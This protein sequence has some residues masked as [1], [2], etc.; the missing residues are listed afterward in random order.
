MTKKLESIRMLSI[1]IHAMIGIELIVMPST[2]VKCAKNNAW[3]CPILVGITILINVYQSFWVMEKFPGLN[4]AEINEKLY[5]AV[6]GKLFTLMF[7]L[8]AIYINGIKLRLFAESINIFLLDETPL[9]ISLAT[10]AIITYCSLMD[11]ETI[12]TFFDILLPTVLLFIFLLMA[13]SLTTVTPQNLLPFFHGGIAPVIKGSISSLSPAATAVIFA[14]I[15]PEFNE[16][17][18]VKKYVNLGVIISIIIY[19][20]IIA[21]CIMVFGATEINYL[22]FPTLTLSKEIQLRS[23]IFERAESLFMAAWIPNTIT[24]AISY[25]LISAIS[26]KAFFNTKKSTVVKLAQ[27]PFIL[28]ISM[29]PRNKVEI[30]RMFEIANIIVLFITFI[31]VPMNTLT[32]FLRKGR[33]KNEA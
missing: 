21:I 8:Y 31:Y 4:L 24:T 30:F 29:L 17:K 33:S 25:I 10:L 23:Q 18:E 15:L 1:I 3:F 19:S 6:L 13:V 27:L 16:P 9:V 22:I 7:A 26:F 11:L 14:F 20:L 28:L 12:S 5:G 32:T 2:T